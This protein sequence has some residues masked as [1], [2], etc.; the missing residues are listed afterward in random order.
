VGSYFILTPVKVLNY[1]SI[2]IKE[3]KKISTRTADESVI[4]ITAD[5]S[6]IAITAD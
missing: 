2:T 6:V 5:E 3:D 4:A 1:V